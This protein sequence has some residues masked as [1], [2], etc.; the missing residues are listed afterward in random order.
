MSTD[1]SLPKAAIIMGAHARQNVY[2][3]DAEA[4]MRRMCDVVLDLP[5]NLPLADYASELA[6]VEL[7]FT[8]WGAPKMTPENLALMPN[9]KAVFYAAGSVRGTVTDTFWEREIPICSAASLNAI[10]VAEYTFAQIILCLKQSFHLARMT[11][12][13]H[14]YVNRAATAAPLGTYGAVVGL[15]SMGEIARRLLERLRTL[16][17]SVKVYDP[18]LAPEKAEALGVSLVSLEELF[19]TSDVVSVHAPWLP[20]TV[21]MITGELLASLK[22]GASFINTAR[23]AVVD[24][25]AMGKV[26]AKR[27]DVQAIIDV[28]YPEPPPPESLLYTLPNVF[29]TPHIA[30]S[31]DRECARMGDAMVVEAKRFLAGQPLTL[32]VTPEV[33][34][35]MA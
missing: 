27:P 25:I 6:G 28:T 19:A 34:A 33:F 35:R 7:L 22:P 2:T 21:G 31:L 9:L 16:D 24:E 15:V 13:A 1:V 29:L 11:R 23:G 26:L 32:Q 18:F 8:S 30:G 17:V 3:A 10:P 14:R 20:E 12:E 5:Q 4:Q